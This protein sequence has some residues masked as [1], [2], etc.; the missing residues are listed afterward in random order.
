MCWFKMKGKLK[1]KMIKTSIK[2]FKELIKLADTMILEA[3]KM[4]DAEFDRKREEYFD[5]HR[6]LSKSNIKVYI[7]K[8]EFIDDME[9]YKQE[10]ER[11]LSKL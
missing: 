2:S 4:S 3:N 11:V 8:Q 1:N 9:F 7:T 6:Y 10:F 5:G